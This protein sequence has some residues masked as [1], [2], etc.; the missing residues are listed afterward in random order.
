M[1]LTF[2]L[3]IRAAYRAKLAVL[4]RMDRMER[5]F[6]EC[7]YPKFSDTGKYILK[8]VFICIITKQCSDEEKVNVKIRKAAEST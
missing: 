7:C 3:N 1:Q 2:R 5:H 8:D 4:A 6:G